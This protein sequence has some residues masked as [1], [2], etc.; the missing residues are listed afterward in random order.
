[1]TCSKLIDK[2]IEKFKYSPN[3]YPRYIIF[4]G[5]EKRAEEWKKKFAEKL[6]EE[7]AKEEK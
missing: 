1:M 2:V 5:S 7:K 4:C 3:V 6:K